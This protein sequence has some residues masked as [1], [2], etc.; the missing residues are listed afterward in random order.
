MISK[1]LHFISIILVVL[2]ITNCSEDEDIANW[3]VEV[4]NNTNSQVIIEYSEY[5]KNWI[6]SYH[7]DTLEVHT[8]KSIYTEFVDK[9][10]GIDAT[11]GNKKKYFS[12]HIELP[13]LNINTEDF[14]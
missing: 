7:T 10:A 4:N 11:L 5:N 9:Y 2:L 6:D 8:T 12:V 3:Y 1:L 13:V 14:K